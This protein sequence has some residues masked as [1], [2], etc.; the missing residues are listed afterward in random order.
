MVLHVVEGRRSLT[1]ACCG[2]TCGRRKEWWQA[3]CLPGPVVVLH[4]VEGR[5]GGKQSVYLAFGRRKEWWQAVCLPGPVVV[6]HVVEERSG[7]KQFAYL[8]LLWYYIW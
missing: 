8:G 7:G 3:V 4:V 5:S 2:I 6:L 1:W